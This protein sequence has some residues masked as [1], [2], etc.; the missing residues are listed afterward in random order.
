ME[1]DQ[2]VDE[3]SGRQAR[4]AK[5]ILKGPE[6]RS[7]SIPGGLAKSERA[8]GQAAPKH[9]GKEG[10]RGK[11]DTHKNQDQARSLAQEIF[12]TDGPG[13]SVVFSQVGLGSELS[14]ALGKLSGW[15]R[16]D[17]SGSSGV[18]LRSS[19]EGGGGLS[20]TVGIGGL[21]TRGRSSDEGR[22]GSG[23]A[24]LPRKKIVHV[25]I[26]SSP[27]TVNGSLDKELIRQVIHR[28]HNQIRYCYESQLTRFPELSGKVTVKFV[29]SATGVVAATEVAS[30]TA[31]NHQ[32]EACVVGR[33]LRWTFPKPKGGGVVVVTYPFLFKQAGQ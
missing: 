25:A 23:T 9:R 12:L 13:G 10:G 17:A 7:G 2:Y 28:N 24:A 21:G 3:L 30:S 14:D 15:T 1:G 8:Q 31:D 4:I 20:H 16:S 6:R 18:G 5:L 33:V 27:L 32:L 29:I 22:Y 26:D 11:K 19:G